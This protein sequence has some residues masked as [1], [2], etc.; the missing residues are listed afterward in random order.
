MNSRQG[1]SK[2]SWADI[3]DDVDMQPINAWTSA[4][5]IVPCPDPNVILANISKS[6]PIE[7][8]EELSE[9]EDSNRLSRDEWNQIR[10][11][12]FETM[13]DPEKRKAIL[14]KTSACRHGV[15]CDRFKNGIN[16][17]FYHYAQERRIPMC[18]FKQTCTSSGCNHCHPGQ[19]EEWL[20]RNPLPEGYPICKP[21]PKPDPMPKSEPTRKPVQKLEPVRIESSV[22]KTNPEA[23]MLAMQ[24]AIN[25]GREVIIFQA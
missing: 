18:P 3:V 21:V 2:M 6:L 16:C 8:K 1:A 11:Q 10:T 22:F 7:V 25:A 5:K 14:Y 20:K 12:G 23:A 17:D 4:P 13:Q 19:E 9:S 24:V 15:N